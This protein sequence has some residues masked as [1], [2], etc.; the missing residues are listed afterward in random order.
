MLSVEIPT[1]SAM[2]AMLCS[3]FARVLPRPETAEAM[4]Y[5]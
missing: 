2:L 5:R 1:W 3:A 4:R